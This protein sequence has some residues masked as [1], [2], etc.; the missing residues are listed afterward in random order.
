[1]IA[2]DHV[3]AVGLKHTR[4]RTGLREDLHQQFQ[5]EAQC[6]AHAQSLGKTGGIDVHHHI[7][8]GLHLSRFARAS[9]IT[10]VNAHRV[11]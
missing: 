1:M 8:Q 9:H 11:E 2:S 7:D 6:L 5:I 3:F 4:I 10:K